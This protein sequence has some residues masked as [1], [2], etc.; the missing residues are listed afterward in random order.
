MIPLLWTLAC[1]PSGAPDVPAATLPVAAIP[2]AIP[3][4][5]PASPA[6]SP[7]APRL[8]GDMLEVRRQ[9]TAAMLPDGF[10]MAVEPPFVLAGD[11]TQAEMTAYATEIVRPVVSAFRQDFFRGDP[12]RAFQIWLFRDRDSYMGNT[13][14]LFG[15]SPDTPY[16]YASTRHGALIMN[17]A[18]GG[19]TLIHE[20]VHPF[21]NADFPGAPSWLN[22]GLASLFEQCEFKGGH[23]I[24]LPNWRLPNLQRLIRAGTLPAFP[25]FLAQDRD[26]F[27]N[28]GAG[29]SYAQARYLC[30]YLQEKGLLIPFYRAFRAAAATDP[31]GLKTLQSVLNEP[32]IAAFQVRWEAWVLTLKK[33]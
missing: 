21:L 31:T 4:A 7:A 18:T 12:E 29:D 19:G 22:E 33:P 32:D 1:S 20:M 9:Q 8:S 16:G 27:Y 5:S 25:A 11:L 24:G 17:I 10:L 2:A 26:T 13:L 28:T 30:L 3:S 23:L 6:A 15:E 14:R